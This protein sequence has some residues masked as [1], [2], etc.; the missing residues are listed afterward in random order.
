MKTRV[1]DPR[2][3]DI[4]AAAAESA[5]L[6]GSWPLAAL[7]RL[8]VGAAEPGEVAWSASLGRRART[9]AEAQPCM[10]LEARTDVALECQR[11]LQPVS[12]SLEVDREFVF[13]A[14]EETAA[15]LDAD[16]EDDVLALSHRFDL[17]ALVEDELLLA[18]P[19][20]PRHEHCPTPLAA[21]AL[22]DAEPAAQH[23]FAALAALKRT[24]R[25]G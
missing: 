13:V 3:L 17:R 10:H 7:G 5:R 19:L 11:C 9:G 15:A 25:R 23:P 6:E 22:P 18:L 20:V 8:A 2:C 24:P 14:D 1:Y 4:A 16:C 12:V 21:K